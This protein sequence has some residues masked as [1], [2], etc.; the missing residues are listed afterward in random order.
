MS[1]GQRIRSLLCG[2]AMIL[3]GAAMLLWYDKAVYLIIV[4]LCFTLLAA[5]IR[6]LIYYFTLARFMVG[7][8]KI[9][10]Y[11]VILTDFAVFANTVMTVRQSYAALYLLGGLAFSGVVHIMRGREARQL[12]APGWK[13]K[14]AH[15]IG[16]LA[17]CFFSLFFLE[18]QI[19]FVGIYCLTLFYSAAVHILDAFRTTDSV[20]IL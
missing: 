3:G 16:T 18:S 12:D 5:G 2:I 10:I 11:G 9:L 7:G 4:I 15:G 1:R 13:M 8:N 20:Y 14:M 19:V 6:Y 17:L